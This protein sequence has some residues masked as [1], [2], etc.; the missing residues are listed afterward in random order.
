M[1]IKPYILIL[2]IGALLFVDVYLLVRYASW[3]CTLEELIPFGA[4]LLIAEGLSVFSI[5]RFGQ[6]IN[7]FTIYSIFV[8]IAGFSF[9]ILSDRQMG[10]EWQF[11]LMMVFSVAF[12]IIGGL[13]SM[14]TFAFSFKNYI[15]PLSSRIS[16]AF[17][18]LVFVAGIGVFIMEVGQLGYL[19]VLNL[20]N[21]AVYQDINEN[22]VTPLHNFIV[23]NSVLPAMFYILYKKK[24]IHFWQ[25]LALSFVCVFIILNF[26]SRQI[27][28][29][30]FFSMLIAYS[31]YKT[32]PLLKLFSIGAACIVLFI[33]LGQLRGSSADE[34]KEMSVNEFLKDYGDITKPTNIIETY[35]SL[36]GAVN[37]SS[38]NEIVS[39][40]LRDDY[41]SY[42]AYSARPLITVLP[43]DKNAIY[44]PLYSSYTKI[45]TYIVD[46]FLDFR[47]FGVVALNFLYGFLSM[48]SFKNYIAKNGEYYIV[49]WSL[50]IFCIF[51]C[52][53]TNFFHMFFVAFFFIVNRLA[54]K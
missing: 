25:F 4:F 27:I 36:Y 20:G 6:M 9:L 47:W 12:F 48:N 32:I 14:K 33:V 49:E 1:G 38:G 31:Y 30:F 51:M 23:L 26:F 52:S 10:Y 7:P 24:T 39:T 16:L 53:F 29:L 42:G 28:V 11:V 45:G 50:F 43:I 13:V 37:F 44:P 15:P 41:V 54:I 22:D 46:P 8:Y 3:G 2:I 17:L 5:I 18:L 19:P 34:D 40:A 21:A 35:L